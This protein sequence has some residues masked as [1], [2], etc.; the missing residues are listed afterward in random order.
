MRRRSRDRAPSWMR[1]TY[2]PDV[3]VSEASTWRDIDDELVKPR[4][5]LL[6]RILGRLPHERKH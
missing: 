1:D 6:S 3:V 5:G 4:R 2:Y